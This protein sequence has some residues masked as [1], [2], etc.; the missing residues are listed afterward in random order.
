[1][2]MCNVYVYISAISEIGHA[3]DITREV[4]VN[5]LEN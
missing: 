3:I 2:C 4:K 1:M 5:T